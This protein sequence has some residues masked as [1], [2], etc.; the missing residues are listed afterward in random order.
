MK[1]PSVFGIFIFGAGSAPKLPEGW[2]I[3]ESPKEFARA[4]SPDGT[5]HYLTKTHA[6]PI[7]VLPNKNQKSQA[8]HETIDMEAAV[9]LPQ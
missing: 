5:E 3:K 4:I 9:L 8:G 2:T 6:V 7:R 1:T